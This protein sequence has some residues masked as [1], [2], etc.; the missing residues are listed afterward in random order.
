MTRDRKAATILSFIVGAGL[1][2]VAALLLAPKS[3]EE[4]RGDIVDGVS[5]RANQ[6]RSTGKNLKQRAEKLVDLA[7]GQVQDAIEAGDNA[8]TQAKKA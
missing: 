3:G 5:D 8:Y 4:L 1:G 6:L 7:K 2:A